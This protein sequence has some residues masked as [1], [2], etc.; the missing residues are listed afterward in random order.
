MTPEPVKLEKQA[1]VGRQSKTCHPKQDWESGSQEIQ[2]R[3]GFAT[4]HVI[5]H[6]N[7]LGQPFSAVIVVAPFLLLIHKILILIVVCREPGYSHHT[8]THTRT[9]TIG[10][11][12]IASVDEGLLMAKF[13]AKFTF[14]QG[15][16]S[17][18][19]FALKFWM[20]FVE[21]FRDLFCWESGCNQ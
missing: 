6:T 14:F 16:S 19:R 18:A 11:F 17:G 20:K 5:T 7:I 1:P 15:Q 3:H 10:H 21:K 2:E 13:D 4:P 8:H 12:G 9:E